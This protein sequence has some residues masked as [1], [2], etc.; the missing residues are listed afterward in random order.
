MNQFDLVIQNGTVVTAADIIRCDVGIKDGKVAALA[1]RLTDGDEV[2]DADGLYVLPGGIDAHVHLDEPPF[3]GILLNDSFESGTKAAAHG[4][5]T[6]IISF[7]QQK[8][9]KPLRESIDEY[10]EMAANKAVIDYGFHVILSDPNEQ[11]VNEEIPV[12]IDEGYTSYKCF[13]T[14]DG[15]LDDGQILRTLE[16]AKRERAM[17]MIHAENE[18]C[19]RH[20]AKKFTDE[21]HTSL[22]YFP[23][24]APMCVEREGTHRAIS[25]SELI[26]TP[27]L[28][29]HVSGREA[30]DQIRW[31]QDRGLKIYG[32]TCP[33]YLLLSDDVYDTQGWEAAKYLFAPPPRD[34]INRDAL[35]RGV[36]TGMF[37]VISSDHNAFQFDSP[38]GKKAGG[39]EPHFRQV[40]PGVPGIE[41]RLALVFSEG[42]SR[43]R[44]DINTFVATT[45]TNPAK[46]YGLYP[47]KGTIAV[48]ADADIAI[49]DPDMERTISHDT[50]HEEVDFTPYEGIEVKGWPVKVYSRGDLIVADDHYV[51]DDGRGQ[52]LRRNR[53][54]VEAARGYPVRDN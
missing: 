22:D 15:Y 20:M 29:V 2:V 4:G 30:M 24:M 36:A 53:V 8:R 33:Q 5:T 50:L 12:L 9:G 23:K 54:D 1:G 49:W 39:P 21:G 31:G 38:A 10:H 17:V 34:S 32:E 27:I 45:A 13:M 42:V 43:G 7:A 44:I 16:M 19:I 48:G 26:D 25:M 46:I 41:A 51:G 40:A 6:T 11:V 14:Y 18:H 47:R 52:F 35:W 28:L 3:Y 37:Q